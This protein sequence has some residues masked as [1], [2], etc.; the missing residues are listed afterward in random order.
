MGI[1][2]HLRRTWGLFAFWVCLKDFKKKRMTMIGLATWVAVFVSIGFTQGSCN[3]NTA[4]AN[5]TFI[6]YRWYSHSTSI[7][8]GNPAWKIPLERF[9]KYLFFQRFFQQ[10]FRHGNHQ[11]SPSAQRSFGGCNGT[12]YAWTPAAPEAEFIWILRRH[13]GGLVPHDIQ[14]TGLIINRDY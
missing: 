9:E 2:N 14:N 4:I 6:I 5:P 10:H 11:A 12:A 3:Q 13:R 8:F 7:K 1:S